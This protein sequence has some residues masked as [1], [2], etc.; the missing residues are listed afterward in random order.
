MRIRQKFIG[1]CVVAASLAAILIGGGQFFLAKAERQAY[2]TR[3]RTSEALNISHSLQIA[4]RGQIVVLKDWLFLQQGQGDLDSYQQLKEQFLDDL[5]QL[6]TLVG[7]SSEI[8]TVRRRY[9]D[10]IQLASPLT[11][12]DYQASAADVRQDLQSLNFFTRDIDFLLE[13][14]IKSAEKND[15]LAIEK[16]EEISQ[17]STVVSAAAIA[18]LGIVFL[19]QFLLI[20]SPVIQAI[21]TL[22]TGIH[23]IAAGD[24]SWHVNIHTRDELEQLAKGFNQMAE[25]LAASYRSLEVQ[26]AAAQSA[27]QAKSEF[28]ANMSHELRTPLNGILGYA[29]ILQ[30]AKDLN[31]HRQGINIIHQSGS[32]LLTLINDVLDLAKIEARKL[33]LLPKD[34]H[35][36]SFLVGIVEVI[37]IKTEQKDIGFSYETEGDLPEG[38]L[39]DDKRLRQVLLNLLGN[40]AKFTDRGGVTFRVD[41][42]ERDESK[43]HL[44][45][46]IQDT[47]VGMKPEQLEKIFLPFEQVGSGAKQAQGTG[48][49]LAISRR[50]V[51][52]MGGEIQ[53]ESTYGEGSR[54]WFDID[55]LLSDSWSAIAAADSSGRIIGYRGPR[56]KVLVV[57]DSAVNRLVVREVLQPL[58]FEIREAENGLVGLKAALEFQP[59]LIITDLVMP[60]MDGF[61]FARK[62]RKSKLSNVIAIASSASVSEADRG[63]SITAGC[64]DFLPK[65]VDIQKLLLFVQKYLHLEWIYEDTEAIPTVTDGEF[66][67]PPTAQLQS[68]HQAAKIG[69]IDAVESLAKAIA[70]GDAR[71]QVF[72]DRILALASEFEDNRIVEL[73]EAH[74]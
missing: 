4:L 20:L 26:T 70:S 2:D 72:S 41:A 50:L 6:E 60:V 21:K 49:G 66:I 12:P 23:K 59:D 10:L 42:L 53:V 44:R 9:E 36:P 18:L 14:M 46:S 55:L 28:L 5:E 57:D 3:T 61:E 62:L 67:V 7:S 63:E 73:L 58:G 37:R 19:L 56:Q 30:R 34:F 25:S 48:L 74:L 39:G 35:F 52:L 1:S 27:N 17:I 54:F 64:D 71:Y 69:D 31:Q 51:E 13:E 8:E 38:V 68:L 47:G 16:V 32:H 22:K 33:E 43:A 11:E 45:F 29:Q 15:R 65:P 24:L 40:A